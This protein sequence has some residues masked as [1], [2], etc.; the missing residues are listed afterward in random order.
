M[1]ASSFEWI[2]PLSVGLCFT[3]FGGL[4]LYGFCMGYEGGRHKSTWERL[5]AG[6]CPEDDCKL[7]KRLRSPF[8]F[9]L[10]LL[11]LGLGLYSLRE[12]FL[13]VSG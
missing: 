8:Y 13:I 1:M 9:L 11:F 10:W 5:R 2:V 3:L 6:K 12:F 7:P 4:K